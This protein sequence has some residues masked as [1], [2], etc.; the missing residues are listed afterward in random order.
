MTLIASVFSPE[1]FA[2]VSDG[3]RVTE[4]GEIIT[5]CAV[6][7]A[8]LVCPDYHLAYGWAGRTSFDTPLLRFDCLEQ[9]EF[10][11]HD[12]REV[13]FQSA[14]HLCTE[15]LDALHGRLQACVG[16]SIVCP[17]GALEKTRIACVLLAGYV[18]QKSFICHAY[19]TCKSGKLLPPEIEHLQGEVNTRFLMSGS[20]TV[21]K[22]MESVPDPQTIEDTI[23]FAREYARRSLDGVGRLPDSEGLGGTVRVAVVTPLS[24]AWDDREKN[25]CPT[26]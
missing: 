14:R 21:A 7:T 5:D 6:K 13:D 4:T 19:I 25:T 16:E 11:F 22:S 23:A 9:M 3:R 8:L 18:K 26:T 24:V 10:A 17:T 12:R 2:V 20:I 15:V 1:G